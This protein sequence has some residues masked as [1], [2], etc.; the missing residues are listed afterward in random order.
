[1]KNFLKTLNLLILITSLVNCAK[2]RFDELG[3]YNNSNE[4]I[5]EEADEVT[6][7]EP[8]NND[9]IW[10]KA[11]NNIYI[12][13]DRKCVKGLASNA[14]DPTIEEKI[15]E[16]SELINQS[17]SNEGENRYDMATLEVRYEDKTSKTFDVDLSQS[18]NGLSN[19]PE[20]K[21]FFDDIREE[22]NRNGLL[23]CRNTG[24]K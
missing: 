5:T 6:Y 11:A 16:L 22:I 12:V 17:Q 20:I 19:S 9:I 14:D 10:S 4:V 3:E 2:S 13:I 18:G 8:N 7:K 21:R 23:T 24:K 15:R 1:M